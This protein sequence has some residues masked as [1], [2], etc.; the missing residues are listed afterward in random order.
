MKKPTEKPNKPTE[1]PEKPAADVQEPTAKVQEPNKEEQEPTE[2]EQDPTEEEQEPSKGFRLP[3]R[4]RAWI[5][6]SQFLATTLSIILTFGTTGIVEHC[7]RIKDRKLS[8]M[9]VMG[10]IETFSRKVD[11]MSKSMARRDS[12]GTWMLS[13]PQDSLDLIPA[14]EM[15]D[16]INEVIAGIDFLTHDKTAESIF[17]SNIETWK[18]MQKFQFID[19]VGNCFSEMNADENYWKEWVED[20]EQAV[21]DVLEHPEQHSGERTCTKLLRNTVFRQKIESFHVRQYWLEYIAAKY[22]YLN[23]KSAKMMGID[24]S[25]VEA[26]ADERL[27]EVDINSA[28]PVQS[29]YRKAPLNADSMNTLR[30]VKL[31]IDSIIHGKK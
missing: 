21:N 19:N 26:F 1:K 29:D 8:A 7:Q 5:R 3:K 16:L 20:F 31:R 10:N 23:Q 4:I 15:V 6:E 24:Y 18:N 9:M 13:L 11:D 27:N 30:P 28:E 17:S 12:I 22:K 2:E 25:E 14:S